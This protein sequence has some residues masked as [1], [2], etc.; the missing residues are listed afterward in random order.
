[1]EICP[2]PSQL[3]ASLASSTL[4]PYLTLHTFHS[5]GHGSPG[6]D[7]RFLALDASSATGA[8]H[9]RSA[10]SRFMWGLL[11]TGDFGVRKEDHVTNDGSFQFMPMFFQ[12]CPWVTYVG[13]TGYDVE[14]A[15]SVRA[16]SCKLCPFIRSIGTPYV[17]RH[18]D[19][20]VHAIT[21][22]NF[23]MASKKS[24]PAHPAPVQLPSSLSGS[25]ILKH[26]ADCKCTD[27]GLH[28]PAARWLL[29]PR[30]LNP[31]P[32]DNGPIHHSNPGCDNDG[33]TAITETL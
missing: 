12:V 32:Y 25:S 9:R 28:N 22:Q 14:I 1:M 3:L 2:D 21:F 17:A 23:L 33:F 24:C 20:A 6:T 8:S 5:A 29:A 16:T 19:I 27:L 18:P 26:P 10:H 30:I 4:R 11:A 13:E 15:E 31:W 7:E